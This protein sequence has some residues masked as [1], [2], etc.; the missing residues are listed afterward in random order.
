M[1]PLV[2]LLGRN[3]GLRAEMRALQGQGEL[4]QERIPGWLL[5]LGEMPGKAWVAIGW[6]LVRTLRYKDQND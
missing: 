4:G 5:D 1:F 2:A 6:I 3:L